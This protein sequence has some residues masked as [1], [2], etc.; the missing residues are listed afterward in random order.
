MELSDRHVL[1]TG[2]SRGIG[3]AM[4]KEFAAAGSRLT[5]V[6]S[7]REALEKAAAEVGGRPLAADLAD[8]NEVNGL[9]TAAE[10]QAGA[11]IDIAVLNAGI[12]VSGAFA[13]LSAADVQRLCQLNITTTIELARQARA[14]M[15]SRGQGHIVAVSS[16]SAQVAMPGLATYAATKAAVSQFIIGVRPELGRDGIRT[17]LVEIGQVKTDLYA[18]ARNNPAT[19][20][21]FDRAV[22]LGLLRDLEVDEVARAVVR[23]VR[24]NKEM[25]VLPRR[26]R[27]QSVLSHTPQ[28]VA[29]RLFRG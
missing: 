4:A 3:L 14:S 6:A 26:A 13:D 2:G 7:G 21:A 25:V 8:T 16:L 12:D 29:H 17:T 18:T 1:V 11:P 27:F 9:V 22:R 28:L 5:L 24:R 15:A 20:R 19:A 10:E 23:A